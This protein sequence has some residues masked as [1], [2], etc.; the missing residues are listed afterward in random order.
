MTNVLIVDTLEDSQTS[1][2]LQKY[3]DISSKINIPVI[4][5]LD[6]PQKD[7]EVTTFNNK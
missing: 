5:L 6:N 4:F 3:V 1:F 2:S 7:F